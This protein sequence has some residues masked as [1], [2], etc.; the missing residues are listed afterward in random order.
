VCHIGLALNRMEGAATQDRRAVLPRCFW[1]Q[2]MAWFSKAA[3]SRGI[4]LAVVSFISVGKRL[5]DVGKVERYSITRLSG[6]SRIADI[7][8]SSTAHPTFSHKIS[9]AT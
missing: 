8:L 5:G 7:A 2:A 6:E 4:R 3:W 9:T 1:I